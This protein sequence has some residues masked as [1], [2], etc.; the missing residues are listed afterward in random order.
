MAFAILIPSL[1][2]LVVLS[3]L[4]LRRR[5]RRGEALSALEAQPPPP[6][7]FDKSSYQRASFAFSAEAAN[8]G[9]DAQPLSNISTNL[10]ATGPIPVSSDPAAPPTSHKG[11]A[12]NFVDTSEQADDVPRQRPT[13][14]IV[15][16]AN[17]TTGLM[18]SRTPGTEF[19]SA[20][21]LPYEKS[22]SDRS[23]KY[24]ETLQSR[25]EALVA[26]NARLTELATPHVDLPPPAYT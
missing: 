8:R 12:S 2:V 23:S 11:T 14:I 16:P 22:P 24:V 18:T 7:W 6:H 1:I 25:I 19:L 5:R 9:V 15:P 20:T 17:P 10:T 3:L 26:E 13:L 4:F 21:T